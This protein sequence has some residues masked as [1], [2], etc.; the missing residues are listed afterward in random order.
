MANIYFSRKIAC[1]ELWETL[2]FATGQVPVKEKLKDF[3]ILKVNQFE[4]KV[5]SSHRIE[6]NKQKCKS[7]SD[8]KQYVGS[9]I[10]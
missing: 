6:I 4:T 8:V 1:D 5:Y 9:R 7:I 10:L 2:F 3:T